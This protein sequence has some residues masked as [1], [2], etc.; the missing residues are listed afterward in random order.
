MNLTPPPP[1]QGDDPIIQQFGPTG[2][3]WGLT[4]DNIKRIDPG[5]GYTILH[6][7]CK[8]IDS[9]PF[10]VFRYLIETKGCDV[11]VQDN[12]NDTPLH[13]AFRHFNPNDAGDINVL[14][15]L[16]NQ[17]IV[18]ANIKGINGYSLLH[19]ACN[20]INKLPIDIFKLLIETHGYDVNTQDNYKDTPL[21]NALRR[22]DPNEGGDITTL[23]YLI[24]QKAV[25]VNIKTRNGHNLLHV[26]CIITYSTKRSV[27][28]N[29]EFD[30]IF[31]QVIKVIVDRSVQLILDGENIIK[32]NTK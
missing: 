27:K 4:D 1:P 15:Y 2:G 24:D 17:K 28:L 18:N 22:F 30:S 29:A 20:N 16:L 5:T 9:I 12:H 10:E 13:H 6:N 25:N 19:Y 11:N 31:C 21:H 32:S 23:T 3:Q 26:A 7:Y 14:T 8:Y